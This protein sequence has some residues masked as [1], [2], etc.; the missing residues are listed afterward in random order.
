M[1]FEKIFAYVLTFR[2]LKIILHWNITAFLSLIVG[3][4]FNWILFSLSFGWRSVNISVFNLFPAY[5]GFL[6]YL[7]YLTFSKVFEFYIFLFIFLIRLRLYCIFLFKIDRIIR[8]KTGMKM[9]LFRIFLIFKRVIF[10]RLLRNLMI[11]IKKSPC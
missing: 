6:Y 8:V 3:F 1:T 9:D 5:N 7:L 11:W 4:H 10:Y 2:A